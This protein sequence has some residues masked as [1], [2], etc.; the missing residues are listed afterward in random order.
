MKRTLYLAASLV[1]ASIAV[2]VA[3]Q[4]G[5][6]LRAGDAARL[7]DYHRAL[8][9]A[10]ESAAA[11]A[12]SGDMAVLLDAFRGEALAPEAAMAALAGEWRCRTIKIG[13]APAVVAYQPFR[14]TI[15]ENGQLA[16]LTGSQLLRG[17]I[18]LDE[19]YGMPVFAG[20]GY[21][22]DQTPPRYED[23]P[24]AI[25]VEQEGQIW[26]SVGLVTMTEPDRGRIVMPYPAVESVVDVL[27]LTR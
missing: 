6:W 12:P 13:G 7:A 22:S 11:S 3:A 19:T 8:G 17:Q 18:R 4:D 10:F 16:K 1:A 25:P 27:V 9:E 2:P 20:V 21:V 15:D 26:S 24:E 5:A 23:L 14:C